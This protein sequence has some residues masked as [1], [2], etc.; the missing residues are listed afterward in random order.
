[1]AGTTTLISRNAA[2]EI[3][4]ANSIWPDMSSD[5]R[6][7]VFASAASNLTPDDST[8]LVDI[9]LYDLEENE[10]RLL[11]V[12]PEGVSGNSS[13]MYP[14]IARDGANVVFS[15]S[16]SN[17]VKWDDPG[18]FDL[19]IHDVTT[20][21]LRRI[22]EEARPAVGMGGCVLSDVSNSTQDGLFVAFQCNEAY[23]A[24]DNNGVPDIY[25]A[26]I[27]TCTEDPAKEAP[28]VCGCGVPDA[29]SNGNGAFDCLDPNAETV[30]ATPIVSKKRRKATITMQLFAG[31]VTY[32][33]ERRCQMK[34]DQKR[35]R[36][37]RSK[38]S[39]A[40]TAVFKL[41]RHSKR[42]SFRYAVAVGEM[43]SQ[44]SGVVMIRTK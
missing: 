38:N 34:V 14:S 41:P 36:I 19:Y 17:L 16:A 37:R 13:S 40:N 32:R 20:K 30:P 29:D 15:S 1:M 23:R 24:G 22:T 18:T 27:D 10:V 25:L 39:E 3:G 12:S 43:T 28:G 44:N 35:R 2:G 5:G 11:S 4:N 42:C 6:Y 21:A 9:F 31:R 8:G 26:Q 7:T 33:P